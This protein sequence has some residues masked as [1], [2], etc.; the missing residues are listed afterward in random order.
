LKRDQALHWDNQTWDEKLRGSALK[1]IK[2]WMWRRNAA[3]TQA[4]KP[5]TLPKN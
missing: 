4:D 2:P 5:P 1:R 3:A